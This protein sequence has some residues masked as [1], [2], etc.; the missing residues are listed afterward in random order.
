MLRIID[1]QQ[2]EK[3]LQRRK[4]RLTEAEGVVGPIL[5]QVRRFTGQDHHRDDLTLV[6]VKRV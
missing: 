5:D 6:T 3:L 4:A 1:Q 2:A